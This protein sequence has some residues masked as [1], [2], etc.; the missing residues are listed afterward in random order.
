MTPEESIAWKPDLPGGSTDILPFYDWLAERLPAGGKFL[1]VGNFFGRS[2][3][4]MGLRRP[5]L[6]LVTCD[7]HT[8]EWDDAGERLPVGPDRERRDKYGGMHEAFKAGLEEHAPG[9][10]ARLH[11]IREPS[12]TGLAQLAGASV[13]ACF[14]DGDHTVPGLLADISHAKR[15]TKPGGI[16]AGH[17]CHIAAWGSEVTRA[18]RLA[19]GVG[20]YELAPWPYPREGWEPGCSSVWYAEQ[21]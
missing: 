4:Y 14:L 6:V 17:D 18:V 10:Y 8:D 20:G 15:I 12:A 1:E 3:A 21:W 5:D 13:D 2:I 9:L 19:F 16:I 11:H 7:P